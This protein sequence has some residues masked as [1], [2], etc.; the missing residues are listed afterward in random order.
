MDK[1]H[2]DELMTLGLSSYEAR[3]Y[4]VLVEHGIMTADE[5]AE[6]ADVPLG[7]IYDVLNSLVDRAIVRSD[8]GRPRTYTHVDPATA[9]DRVLERRR[10]ELEAK[11]GEYERTASNARQSLTDL[12]DQEPTE[13]FATSA[14]HDASAVEVVLEQCASATDSIRVLVDELPC[15]RDGMGLLAE[16]LSS[17]A[18]SGVSVRMQVA[19]L[20]DSPGLERLQ[21]AG[22]RI[23]RTDLEP[24][25]RVV[26]ADE[27]DVCL[28]VRDPLEPGHRLVVVNF[29]DQAVAGDLVSR[30][31]DRW[32]QAAAEPSR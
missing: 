24:Y 9:I 26:V 16:R 18:R 13:R 25:Q 28:E 12:A 3:A 5:V 6:E 22:V 17:A 30:F 21:A 2:V 20:N 14:F 27:R 15:Q 7:R 29:R 11:R 4:A 23:R 1:S 10:T 32:H 19:E 31:D 8:D